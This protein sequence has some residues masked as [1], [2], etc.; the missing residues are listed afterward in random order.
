M[1]R[2]RADLL[3]FLAPPGPAGPSLVAVTIAPALVAY[4]LLVSG[5]Y[6]E[7]GPLLIA[8]AVLG[9]V[10]PIVAILSFG[11][12]DLHHSGTALAMYEGSC[13]RQISE[14][15]KSAAEDA[16]AYSSLLRLK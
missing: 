12:R 4:L 16:Q 11:R 10:L 1:P 5:D 2:S 13:R 9:F 8:V 3:P 7:L 6:S 14:R 15:E